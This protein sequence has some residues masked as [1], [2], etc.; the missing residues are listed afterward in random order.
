MRIRLLMITIASVLAVLGATSCVHE[1]TVVD[2]SFEFVAEVSYDDSANEHRLTL[3]RKSGLEDNEYRIAFSMDGDNTVSLKNKDGRS[4]EGSMT[5][6]FSD[7]SA[8]IY[9]LETLSPGEHTLEMEISTKEYKQSLSVVFNVEDF[10]FEFDGKVLFDENTKGHALELTLKQGASADRYTISFTVDNKEPRTTYQVTFEDTLTRTYDLPELEPGEHT[11]NVLITTDKHS[12]EMD[13][14]YS[15]NDYS[16]EIK[17]E[18]EY[19]SSKLSHKLFLT[20]EKGSRDENYTIAYTVDG[21]HSVK[22]TDISGRELSAS[23]SENFKDVTIRTYSMSRAGIGKHTMK[24][25][26]STKDYYQVIEVPY[27]VKAIP[28]AIHTQINTAEP[29]GTKLMLSLKEGDNATTYDVSIKYDGE[30]IKGYS[31]AEVNFSST[32]IKTLVLPLLR[33]GKHNVTVEVTDGYTTESETLNYSEPVRHPYVDITLTHN[34]SNGKH[35]ATVADNPYGIELTIKTMLTITG[36]STFCVTTYADS[37]WDI[38]YESKTKLMSDSSTLTDDYRNTTVTI[39][40]RDALAAKMTSSYEMSNILK[41]YGYDGDGENSS[42]YWWEK[43]GQ[44]R[45][46][47]NITKEELKVDISGEKVTGVTLRVKNQ[48]GAMT[49]NGKSNSSGT[50]NLTL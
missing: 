32:P 15:V 14:P 45:A 38:E 19:D 10:S 39:I 34:D 18:I 40:D 4:Y 50:T 46:Y 2:Y 44:E 42:Y 25:V 22:L 3:T 21:G 33:P 12:Q 28:F 7:I 43:S 31:T 13:I 47:Y 1:F 36:K 26:I 30:V 35:L 29:A 17:A 23:F 9:T 41:E 24:L 37:Y 49:L 20:L 6:R 16:F 48:I 8:R 11:V 5:E 27:Q